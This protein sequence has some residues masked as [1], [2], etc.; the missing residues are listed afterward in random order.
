MEERVQARDLATLI[1]DIFI[2]DQKQ[3]G[4]IQI[5]FCPTDNMIGDYMTNPLH[6]KKFKQ[7]RDEIMNLP[8]ANQF[9]M[10]AYIAHAYVE[11]KPFLLVK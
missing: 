9:M 1:S 2:N 6:G 7:F 8:V 11:K 4:N 3:K 10:D 5:E